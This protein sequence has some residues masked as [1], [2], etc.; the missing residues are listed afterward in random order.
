MSNKKEVLSIIHFF[1]LSKVYRRNLSNFQYFITEKMIY[2]I[3]TLKF[4]KKTTEKL[5]ISS[6]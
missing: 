4:Y 5:I 6:Q 3:V 1:N 2:E